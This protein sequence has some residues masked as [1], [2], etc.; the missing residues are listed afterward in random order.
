MSLENDDS[1][2]MKIAP[3]AI[4]DEDWLLFWNDKLVGEREWAIL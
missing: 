2:N 1:L 3:S 4:N